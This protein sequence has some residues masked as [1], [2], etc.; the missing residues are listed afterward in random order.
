MQ[1]LLQEISKN[2]KDCQAL[3]DV[4]LDIHKG[5]LIALVGPSGSGKTTLLKIIAGL[6][7]PTKG[8]I[9]I[10]NKK[11]T[12]LSPKDRNIGF[13]FQHY[14]LFKHMNVYENIA[15]PYKVQPK[16]NRLS[17]DAIKIR[18]K[19][20]AKLVQIENL[21]DRYSHELSG[22]QR[23]RVALARA[24]AVEPEILLLDEPFAALD[25]KLKLELRRWL[26]KLQ[27]KNNIT[28]ILVTHDQEEALDLADR[29]LILNSGVV[30][31]VGTPQEVYHSPNN[32]FVYNF[33]GHYNLFKAIKDSQGQISILNQ[34]VK[35]MVK[36]K[37]WYNRHKVVSTIAK[38]LTSNLTKEKDDIEE[39]FEV[40]VRPH[41]IEISVK[42]FDDGYIV[43]KVAHINLAAPIV[44]LEL[45]SVEYELIQVEISHEDFKKLQIE[46]NTQ[47][48]IK[49]RQVTMFS[50]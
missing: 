44:K 4:S 48:Y 46:K 36:E 40:F 37:K 24:L 22:G 8:E 3:S 14:A 26:R 17:E 20:L 16:K 7:N 13:V 49:P 31:Q 1:I 27:Q 35:E 41:D 6:E 11:V 9:Y 28:I 25:A 2:Y 5:E 30:E 32:S 21:L 10:N 43:A 12:N 50:E 33:L 19:E 39:Y 18:V 42:P 45:E 38:L 47:V 15:F 29:V 34:A 23:Q